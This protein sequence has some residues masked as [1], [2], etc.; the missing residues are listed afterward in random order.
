MR[1]MKRKKKA[2][3]ALNIQVSGKYSKT[4]TL[5]QTKKATL[6]FGYNPIQIAL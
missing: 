4:S 3:K 5:G 2:A 6:Y 1:K